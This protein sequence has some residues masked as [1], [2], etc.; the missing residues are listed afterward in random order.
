M[1]KYINSLNRI[2]TVDSNIC[3]NI[4]Q[5][6]CENRGFVSQNILSQLRN[7]CES[8]M[9]F[10][11]CNHIN[12]DLIVDWNS[13]P[14]AIKYIK[15][16]SKYNDMCKLHDLLQLTESHYTQD[17]SN[18][19]R[20]MIRYYEY[21]LKLKRIL[22]EEFDVV[23]LHNLAKYPIDIDPKYKEYYEQIYFKIN[24]NDN[25][26]FDKALA[27]KC[28]VQSKHTII[29]RNDIMYELILTP[30]SDK[31]SKFDRIIAFTKFDIMKNYAVELKI[32]NQKIKVNE[33]EMPIS[34]IIDWQNSIRPCELKNLGKTFGIKF[35]INRKYQEYKSLMQY[36]TFNGKSLLDIVLLDDHNYNKII[37][38]IYLS[39]KTEFF[40]IVLDKCREIIVNDLAGS[41]IL[42]LFLHTMNNAVIKDQLQ[43]M[44]NSNISYLYLQNTTLPFDNLPFTFSLRKHNFKIKDLLECIT[45]KNREYEFLARKIINNSEQNRKLYTKIDELNKFANIDDLINQYNSKLWHG[46]KQRTIQKYKDYLF[47]NEYESNTKFV[48]D[49]LIELSESNGFPNN[50]SDVNW[51]LENENDENIDDNNK[52]LILKKL[53]SQSRVALIYGAAGT[54]KTTMIKHISHFYNDESKLYLT[55]TNPALENLKTRINYSNC[56][57]LTISKVINSEGIRKCDILF[58]D[59]CSTVSN[60]DMYRILHKIKFDMLVLVGDIYQIESIS[61]GNWF[62]VARGFIPKHSI[63]ELEVPFRT[64]D[65]YL[66]DFWNSMRNLKDDCIDKMIAYGYTNEIDDSLFDILHSDEIILCLHYDGLY[67]VNNVNRLLQSKNPNK[68]IIIGLNSY[69]IGD[70]VLFNDSNRFYPCIYNNM[71]GSISNI[72]EKEDS[73]TFYV[74]L[75]IHLKEYSVNSV[76]GLVYEGLSERS[77]TIVSFDVEKKLDADDDNESEKAIMPFQ[78]AYAVSIH[79]AQGLEYESVKLVITS[80]VE[81]SFSHNVFYTAVTRSKKY[82]KIYCS[83][84]TLQNI[85]TSFKKDNNLRDAHIFAS[86]YKMNYK[87]K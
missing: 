32:V 62:D 52:T 73:F 36:L 11:Y 45:Y 54:G 81:E 8:I 24:S 29:L 60:R 16:V 51:W 40:R 33:M 76:N 80:D 23:V 22:K 18:S 87:M 68:E 30:A 48:I 59:E 3:K 14:L 74:E 67:G 15:T 6:T 7:F 58:I 31:V 37:N 44:A 34:I 78:V 5:I 72:I 63:F 21:L 75:N 83:P 69:K 4:D 39:S 46:H 25:M 47:I 17:E 64:N 2:K 65:S 19:E 1:N 43:N 70:P 35:D 28:Y 13:I 27:T 61:F 56:E 20:L 12:E 71:K 55:N 10:C 49:K 66:L 85:Y 53:F 41:N 82:L 42:R 57:Y 26:P 9:V 38:N 86:K 77:N 50:E 84:E 79:K